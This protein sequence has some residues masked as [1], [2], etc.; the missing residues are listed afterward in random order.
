MAYLKGV[1]VSALLL[2][3]SVAA[4][5]CDQAAIHTSSAQLQDARSE[6]DNLPPLT[7]LA[8]DSVLGKRAVDAIAEVKARLAAFTIAYM[9]CQP[10]SIDAHGIDIDLSRLGWASANLD[11]L[12][13]AFATRALAQGLIGIKAEFAVPCGADTQLM[14]FD[15]RDG[16]WQEAMRVASRVNRGVW[17]ARTA[18]DY[19]IVLS[20]DDGSWMLVEKHLPVTCSSVDTTITYSV[21]RPTANPQAPRTLFTRREP[22]YW[23]F[24]DFGRLTVAPHYFELRFHDDSVGWPEVVRRYMILHDTVQPAD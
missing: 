24:E 21:L 4:A 18:F 19:D 10:T 7:P 20:E 5:S 22:I 14:I 12:Y 3:P 6:L 11:H 2:M 16:S 17:Q 13:L 23:G 15:A 1:L 9:R 8:T